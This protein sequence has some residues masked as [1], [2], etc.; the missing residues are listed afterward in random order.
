MYLKFICSIYS[1][2][3]HTS[4]EKGQKHILVK[5]SICLMLCAGVGLPL[6]PLQDSLQE[7]HVALAEDQLL[8]LVA[9]HAGALR[10]QDI[11]GRAEHALMRYQACL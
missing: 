8:K 3:D 6:L 10:P 11:P 9:G 7:G 1:I 5:L 4:K 2:L